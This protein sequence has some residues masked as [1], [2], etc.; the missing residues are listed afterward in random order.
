MKCVL[1][2]L[3][4]VFFLTAPSAWAATSRPSILFIAIDDQNDWL[5]CLSGHPQVKTPAIDKL[6]KRGT[7]FTEAHCQA[8][9][10]NPSRSSVLTGLRPSTTGIYALAPGIRDV[11]RTQ[12]H[13]TL[14]QTFTQAGYHTFTCG[15]IYH[16]GSIK[17]KLQDQE[18]SQWG[19]SGKM[20]K[21]AANLASFPQIP[22]KLLMDF[23]IHEGPEQELADVQIADAAITALKASPADQPFFIA[24]GFRLP[25]LPCYATQA[26]FDLYPENQVLL[27]EIREDDRADLP[28]FADFLHWRL[29]ELRLTTLQGAQQWRPLVRSYLA[30]TSCMDAQVGRLLTALEASGRADE[31]LVILW[32]DH[33]WHLGEKGITGKNSLWNESTRVPLIFAGPGVHADQKCS[34]PVELLDIFPTLLDLAHLPARTDLEGHSLLPQL[35]DATISRPWPAITTHNPGNHSV[36]TAEWRYTQYADGSEELYHETT[37]PHEWTNLASAPEH[38]AIKATLRAL[39]PSTSAPPAPGSKQRL[40]TYDAEKK[41]A[42]WEGQLIDASLPLPGP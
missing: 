35:K 18:F 24:A 17:K 20:P 10:C 36:R 7:L 39:L 12:Q 30:C 4:F 2:G 14:P 38:S 29:P 33:G 11:P 40:L 16:D 42:T 41:Q 31:T 37:D 9:L 6:A 34:Q 26:W 32:S 25:H 15:K 21:P 28:K 5:G 13:V 23:G 1:Q 27:P 8:P 3:L 19:A 22:E